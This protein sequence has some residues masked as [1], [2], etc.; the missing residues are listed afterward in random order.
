MLLCSAAAQMIR[1]EEGKVIHFWYIHLKYGL[2]FG[3]GME[4]DSTKHT[5]APPTQS[6]DQTEY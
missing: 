2:V 5:H 1:E 3:K 4:M 6:F